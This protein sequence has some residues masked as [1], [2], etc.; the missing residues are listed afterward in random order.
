MAALVDDNSVGCFIDELSVTSWV[1]DLGNALSC[2][3]GPNVVLM[4][5]ACLWTPDDDIPDWPESHLHRRLK[6]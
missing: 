6:F 4:G 3:G 2:G 1:D 5:Q